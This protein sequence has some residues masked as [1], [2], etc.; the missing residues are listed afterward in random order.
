MPVTHFMRLTLVCLTMG[1]LPLPQVFAQEK[2]K[3]DPKEE[4]KAPT[5]FVVPVFTLSSAITEQPAAED[6][7]FA[8]GSTPESF[9]ALTKRLRK[10]AKDEDV[11]GVVL[12]DGG[13][14]V[15]TAQIEELHQILGELKK[16]DKKIYAHADWLDTKRYVLLSAA[17]HVSVTP[18]G[19]LFVTGLYGEQL[20]LR[21]LF[22][23]IG[24]KPDFL[25]CGAYK[26]AA[27]MFM[28]K[29]AS[30][31]AAEMYEWLFD[32]LYDSFLTMIAE[33]RGVKKAQ[34]KKWIDQGLYSAKAAQEQGLIDAAEYR[35]DFESRV[36]KDLG[37]GAT[38]DFRYAK[39]KQKEIDLSNPFAALQIWAEIL[40][41]GK[42]S[43]SNKD[44]VGVVYVEGPIMPGKGEPSLFGGSDGAY[45][46]PI[47]KALD[48]VADDDTIKAVVLR[49]D[50]PGGSVVA[51]E[52]IL[53]ASQRV[54][55][56]KP[57][58]VSMGNVAGS[59]GYYVSCGTETIFAEPGTI[60][61]SIGVVSGKLATKDMWGKIG[62]NFQPHSRGERA[63]MLSSAHVFT[64]GEKAEMQSW[65]DE[66]YED[67]KGHVLAVRKDR[68][69]KPIDDLAGGRVFTGKQAL[70]YGLVDKLGG[71]NDAIEFAAKQAK[72]ED[73]EV[74]VVPQPKNF[75]ELLTGDLNKDSNKK[76][77]N[78]QAT[79]SIWESV[80]PMLKGL[81]PQ[82][83]RIV[84]QAFQQLDII[85]KERATLTMP[86]LLWD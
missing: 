62:I 57:L 33:G 40:S 27:E 82:R 45:S 21:G 65:M 72:V 79:G 35:L 36:K 26:S 11:K 12:L 78:L 32:G 39:A 63:G 61:G 71:L 10:A 5:K 15:G 8:M 43:S 80:L 19:H 51:S 55:A 18:T 56:K 81:D 1:L 68:L 76:H 34:A 67:F 44:A 16:A 59:G 9:L 14:G 25:T 77:L 4:K 20:Y 22:D 37:E 64:K 48:K 53:K 31:E 83:M 85:Q 38:F 7:P 50:S 41:G 60:T 47:R 30:P 69:S 84:H 52:I 3:A 24:V 2:T 49:V 6:M 23:R 54:K 28:R 75:I 42:K 73:Y 29:E 46:D 58:I 74:R 86:L 66:V 70:E 17:D 13:A